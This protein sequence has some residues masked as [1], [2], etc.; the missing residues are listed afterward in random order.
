M[1]QL[2][3]LQLLLLILILLLALNTLK[4]MSF[5]RN[6]EIYTCDSTSPSPKLTSLGDLDCFKSRTTKVTAAPIEELGVP[7]FTYS[8]DVNAQKPRK[9]RLAVIV[10]AGVG[11]TMLV[12]T[13]VIIVC[14]CLMR[15]RRL[16]RR[17][18]DTGSSE[19][20]SYVDGLRGNVS[21]H[22]GNLSSSEVQ[23][24]SQLTLA[25]LRIATSNFSQ[26]N[27]IGEGGFGLV[28]KGLLQDGSIVAIK[29][30][31]H[32]PSQYFAQEV[33]N[34]GQIR[35]RH[36]VKL[37]GYCQENREQLLVYDYM[38]NGNVGNHLYDS[39]GLPIGKLDI[40]RRLSIALGA[41]RGLEFLH[42]LVPPFLHMHFRTC[43]VLLD[44]NFTAK[45]ADVGLSRFLI[46]SYRAGPSSGIDYFCDPELSISNGFSE[47][48][49]VYSF[50]VFLLEL[51]SGREAVG[52][53]GSV[54]GQNLIEWAKSTNDLNSFVDPVLRK[55]QMEAMQL[56]MELAL[57]C[58]EIG[59]KR[60]TMMQIVSTLELIHEREMGH[61]KT[62]GL[63]EE[64]GVVTLGSEL[65]K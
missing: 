47:R 9:Q 56:V 41:A 52:R 55:V 61:L 30:R 58:V 37:I 14:F 40:C 43:N 8:Q 13:V 10:G 26:S 15:A 22:V 1:H 57:Q 64:I 39:E 21:P 36:I 44:E 34:L 46:G 48:T 16:A 65:F 35:H 18:S 11:A 7:T 25:E 24:I 53:A 63:D 27:I 20:S 59:E 51:I 42:I 60:P 5:S 54:P 45:V 29:Q 62:E 28:Y 4:S 19:S 33:Q 17:T 49:D 23:D 31:F 6:Q 12:A 32:D 50:G 2:Q 38:A 3:W